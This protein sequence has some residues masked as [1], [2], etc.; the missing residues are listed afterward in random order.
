MYNTGLILQE[1]APDTPLASVRKQVSLSNFSPNVMFDFFAGYPLPV[2]RGITLTFFSYSILRLRES[3]IIEH[4][5]RSRVS[6]ATECLKPVGVE[7]SSVERPLELG[8]FYGVF[9]VY[10]VG[11][12]LASLSFLLEFVVAC[13]R[14]TSQTE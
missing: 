7:S 13:G 10:V 6:N 12:A 3:G 1:A 2:Y 5:F 9:I 8:D 11:I 14:T 4:L